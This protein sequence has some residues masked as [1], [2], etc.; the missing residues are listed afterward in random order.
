MTFTP[1]SLAHYEAKLILYTNN[2]SSPDSLSLDGFGVHPVDVSEEI[3]RI[4]SFELFQNYPNPF[5][6]LTTINF[7][8]PVESKVLLEVYN[9]LGEKIATL[10]DSELLAGSYKVNFNGTKISSGIYFYKLK[11][12][13]FVSIKK[14]VLIK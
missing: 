2:Y 10:V 4:S 8:I 5:N 9:T 12:G 3:N 6:P 14:F 13:N 11:A 7:N 1:T